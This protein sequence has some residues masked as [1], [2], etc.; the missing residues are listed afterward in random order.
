MDTKLV[1]KYGIFAVVAIAVNMLSQ[2]GV[3][4]LIDW[5]YEIYAGLCIGTLMGLIVKYLLDKKYIFYYTTKDTREDIGKFVLYSLMGVVTTMI[6]WGM[7][8]S[9]HYII[10]TTWAK[11]LGGVLGLVIGY[12]T[13]YLLDS[14][15]VF[16]RKVN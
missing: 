14:R 9:F 3:F 7:E 5:R 16:V 10:K 6:F 4:M 8:L 12:T 13:K 15:Y 11:Y 2:K 1:I